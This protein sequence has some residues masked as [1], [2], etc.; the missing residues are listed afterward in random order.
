MGSKYF[1]WSKLQSGMEM[2]VGRTFE[3]TPDALAQL[4][5]WLPPLSPSSNVLEV[6]AG[7]GYFT[8]HLLSFYPD[9]KMT[10]LEP[11]PSLA[12]MLRA[13]YP[14]MEV[15]ECTL[16]DPSIPQDYYDLVV[17]HIVIHN[18]PDC[19]TGVRSMV[20]A[21]KFG[22]FV[23]TIEPV[24]GGH[25]HY[26]DRDI[27]RAFDT[28][29]QYKVLVHKKRD[30]MIGESDKPNPF[31]NC[32]AEFFDRNGLKDIHTYGITSVFTLSDSQFPFDLRKRWIRARKELYSEERDMV[33]KV[34][35]EGGMSQKVIDQAYMS[36]FE[37]FDRLE[38]TDEAELSH[39][40]EQEVG[41]RTVTVG[42]K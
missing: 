14:S 7:S 36:L 10:A 22:G 26:T 25:T 17:S 20:G 6:G 2:D 5:K 33:T 19:E 42:R 21:A 27:E 41:H 18:L 24:S 12:S 3:Y 23:V 16:E 30:E 13:K 29:W 38:H 8:Q 40:H 28:L 31:R 32:Y 35:L 9:C 4:A 37:Y 15:V 34:L 39:I 1:P 11:D